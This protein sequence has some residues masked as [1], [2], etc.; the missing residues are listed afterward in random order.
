MA[1]AKDHAIA[2]GRSGVTPGGRR[3]MRIKSLSG[4]ADAYGPIE[5]KVARFGSV[6]LEHDPI[7]TAEAAQNVERGRSALNR[8]GAALSAPGVKLDVARGVPLYHADP[9]HPD[10]LVRVLDGAR[11]SGVLVDGEFK[12]L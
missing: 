3:V 12:A 5:T 11:Q 7:N 10:R 2:T 6:S 1:R 4:E 8:M 9:H